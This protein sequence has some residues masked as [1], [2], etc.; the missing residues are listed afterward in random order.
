MG[1]KDEIFNYVMSSPEDTNPS[2]LKSLLNEVKED[3]GI[4]IIEIESKSVLDPDT[5]NYQDYFR[6]KNKSKDIIDAWRAGKELYLSMENVVDT[7]DN[8]TK[9]LIKPTGISDTL[10]DDYYN[11][12]SFFF[13][14]A[15]TEG[16]TKTWFGLWCVELYA[17][18]YDTDTPWCRVSRKGFNDYEGYDSSDWPEDDEET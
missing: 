7:Y 4:F 14:F 13:S 10:D 2:V 15:I 9:G 1:A 8:Y 11:A 17:Y 6:C 18:I 12:L 5:H 3:K 16:I